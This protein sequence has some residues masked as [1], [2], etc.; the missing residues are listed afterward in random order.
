MEIGKKKIRSMGSRK[1][2]DMLS[3]SKHI[4]VARLG[5]FWK[6]DYDVYK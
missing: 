5:V 4:G 1:R 2:E 3:G 6:Y